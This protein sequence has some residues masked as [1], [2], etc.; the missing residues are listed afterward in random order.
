[1]IG[2]APAPD[3]TVVSAWIAGEKVDEDT[4]SDGKY[5]LTVGT[6]DKNYTGATVSFKVA[7]SDTGVTS[8]W[9][10]GEPVNL[11]FSV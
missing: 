8:T 7:G 5:V 4:T 3:G 11:D 1:M 10:A 9:I 6:L 2:G